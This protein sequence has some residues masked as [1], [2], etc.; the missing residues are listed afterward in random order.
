MTLALTTRKLRSGVEQY[1]ALED[2]LYEML[3]LASAILFRDKRYFFEHY[4]RLQWGA[5]KIADDVIRVKS[6]LFRDFLLGGSRAQVT[7][8]LREDFNVPLVQL[9]SPPE[10]ADFRKRIENSGTVH[11]SWK[12]VGRSPPT[13]ADR[14]KME[15]HALWLLDKAREFIEQCLQSGF[16]LAGYSNE[17]YGNFCRVHDYLKRTQRVDE[18]TGLRPVGGMPLAVPISLESLAQHGDGLSQR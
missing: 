7:D 2:I 5:P 4:P 6:R 18:N 8:I 12:R 3:I 1:Q 9:Q 15:E 16:A 13:K 14:Q 11:L 10:S 17:L